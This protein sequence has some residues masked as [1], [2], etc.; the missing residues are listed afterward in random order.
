MSISDSLH[1]VGY[2]CGLGAADHNCCFGP[3]ILQNSAFLR[4]LTYSW[5]WVDNLF[6][7]EDKHQLDAAFPISQLCDQLAKH[8]QRLITQKHLFATIGGDHSSSLGTWSGAAAAI[9]GP[10]GLLWID[11]HM[12]AHIPQTSLTHNIHGMPLAC[13]LGHGD[14]LLTQTSNEPSTIQP[15]HICLVGVRSFEPE[16][17]DLLETLEVKVF[18][19]EEI[20]ERGLEAVMADALTIVNNNTT[21]YG[22]SIDVDAIDPTEAPGTG[23]LA[24]N[25]LHGEALCHSLAQLKDY[26]NLLGIEIAEFNPRLDQQQKTEKLIVQLIQSIL[27][28]VHPHA[29]TGPT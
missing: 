18:F 23:C 1:I 8:I 12:D 20:E 28:S 29:S 25:G 10:L 27:E 15:E 16:E 9:D 24:P 19:M 11:A 22:I 14:A 3:L 2:A 5:R 26:P 4:E 7:N 13:L 6:P 21:G 17:A